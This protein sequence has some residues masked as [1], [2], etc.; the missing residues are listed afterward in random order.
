MVEFL[1]KNYDVLAWSQGDIPRIDPQV[2]VYE[3]FTDLDHPLVCQKGRKFIPKRLK[4]IEEEVDKL[5]KANAIRKFHY[6]DWL[7]NVVV[8]LKNRGK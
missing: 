5:I 6:P 3:L 4:V 2:A 1:K 8:I 7:A